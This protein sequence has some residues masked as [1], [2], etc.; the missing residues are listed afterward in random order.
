MCYTILYNTA[1]AVAEV[2][3]G[4][5]EWACQPDQP[6]HYL[7]GRGVQPNGPRVGDRLEFVVH[8]F[9]LLQEPAQLPP[10]DL[11]KLDVVIIQ[12][13]EN[14]SCARLLCICMCSAYAAE[15]YKYRTRLSCACACAC[16]RYASRV[17][18]LQADS[19]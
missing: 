19:V 18:S 9:G 3:I 4:N 6:V 7:T 10:S 14:H 12:L 8:T 17:R 16:V 5:L 15:A 13:N 11:N 1:G 2:N